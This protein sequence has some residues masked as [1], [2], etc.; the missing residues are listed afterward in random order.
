MV[1]RTRLLLL[2][3]ALFCTSLAA[4]EKTTTTT[5]CTATA[6][7][8]KAYFDLR[9]DIAVG[10]AKDGKHK[11]AKSEDY[12]AR[13]YD[14]GY[15]FTLNICEAV[16]Q[17]PEKVVGI[18]EALWKNVSAYYEGKDGKTYS[19]GQQSS[20]LTPRGSQLVLQYS[21]GSPCGSSSKKRGANY[22][23]AKDSA[24]SSSLDTVT[25]GD[26]NTVLIEKA[27]GIRRKS[28]TISFRC[29]RESVSPAATVSFVGA[30]PDECNYMFV[31]RSQHACA[32]VQ[33]SKPGSVGPGGVFALIFFIAI[34]VYFA[35]GVF[36]QRTVANARGWKQLPNYSLWA[37]IWSFVSDTFIILTSSCARFMPSRRGYR[38]LSIS[39]NGRG[40]GRSR[41]D[42]DRLIGQLDEEW[43]D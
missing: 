26:D 31:V 1:S 30:D 25:I 36:Y 23:D 2:A 34:A 7:G 38:S 29:D 12:T 27:E 8:G 40:M 10:P 19:L 28:A 14:Y 42:E 24:Y 16:I 21:G 39:P 15:N 5:A 17:K 20:V 33:P 35:G 6:T 18:D 22:D 4:D 37:G 3:A 41:E 32:G 9:P 11:R 13:G 43:D